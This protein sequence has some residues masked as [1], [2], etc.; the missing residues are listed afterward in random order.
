MKCLL[1]GTRTHPLTG[2]SNTL[3]TEELTSTHEQCMAEGVNLTINAMMVLLRQSSQPWIC[4]MCRH[5][6]GHRAMDSVTENLCRD[7][8]MDMVYSVK[9]Y[10][11]G[12][13]RGLLTKADFGTDQGR[14]KVICNYG[15]L[16]ERLLN[17]H[18][19]A[20]GMLKPFINLKPGEKATCAC[21]KGRAP[22][23]PTNP[24]AGPGSS[25]GGR[26][27]EEVD[28]ETE[29]LKGSTSLVDKFSNSCTLPSLVAIK[30]VTYPSELLSNRLSGH[31][32]KEALLIVLFNHVKSVAPTKEPPKWIP[33]SITTCSV[34]SLTDRWNFLEDKASKPTQRE[35]KHGSPMEMYPGTEP[36][37]QAGD[38]RKLLS[39]GLG[40]DNPRPA[41]APRTFTS[42]PEELVKLCGAYAQATSAACNSRLTPVKLMENLIDRFEKA[43]E[44]QSQKAESVNADQAQGAQVPAAD[45]PAAI[46]PAGGPPAGNLAQAAPAAPIHPASDNSGNRGRGR[47][48]RGGAG[49]AH[50]GTSQ[51]PRQVSGGAPVRCSH[52]HP[53]GNGYCGTPNFP[54]AMVC[55]ECGGRV[56]HTGAGS[57]GY[58]SGTNQQGRGG[59]RGAR[60]G[61]WRG[62]RGPRGY[63]GRGN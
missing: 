25:S 51:G 10:T 23:Q 60:G 18:G 7:C 13:I 28:M 56:S 58:G 17:P 30:P 38:K 39:L 24:E 41:K 2:G 34:E 62:N 9:Y 42:T 63:R 36:Q 22:K 29:A 53:S 26:S 48:G 1:E 49:P 43:R 33:A 46:A 14:D 54:E 44:K 55:R 27:G 45:Q 50:R 19:E 59:G 31:E 40:D 35:L 61:R 57:S 21:E 52:P 20:T 12:W 5:E 11:V 15:E 8:G 32:I 37:E 16:A 4:C 47:G 6:H 3:L